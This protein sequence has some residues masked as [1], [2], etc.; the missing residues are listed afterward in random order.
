MNAI[1][2]DSQELYGNIRNSILQGKN[3]V[4]AAINAGMIKVYWE[5]GKH[6]HEACEGK[7]AEY[8]RGLIEAICDDLTKEFG[9]SYSKRNLYLMRQFY[10]AFPIVNALRS[11]LS[12]THY[13]LLMR[14]ADSKAR[15]FYTNECIASGWSSRELERQITTFAYQRTLSEQL[16]TVN[17]DNNFNIP[18]EDFIRDPY[19]LEF[20]NLKAKPEFYEKD[21]EQGIIEHL[22][23]FLLELGRGFSFVARQKHIEIDGDHFYIDLVFYNYILK[24]F[25]LIDLKLGK[26]K[27]Q[28]MGQMQMY[29]N[30]Y[31][32]K[33]KNEGD[34]DPIG[35]VLCA[36][37]NDAVVKYTLGDESRTNIYASKYL[38]YMPTEDELKQELG[39]DRLLKLEN[40]EG[41]NDET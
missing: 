12:W 31:K 35:I 27:H 29:V 2:R 18:Y 22:Q 30:F 40:K 6:I 9:K 32:D 34:N 4:A 38:P 11:Q 36:E 25:V 13:R 41:A 28:D 8:G 19:V 37:K 23:E 16:P 39:L 17:K 24:C 3:Y 10:E 1:E 15:D 21:I 5:I 26:L 7:R 14:V 33:I 20:L